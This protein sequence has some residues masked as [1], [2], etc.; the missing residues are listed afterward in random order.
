MQ[1]WHA[2]YNATQC[3]LYSLMTTWKTTECLTNL[4]PHLYLLA[5]RSGITVAN[6]VYPRRGYC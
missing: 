1:A 5:L 6:E 4:F 2:H 3:K